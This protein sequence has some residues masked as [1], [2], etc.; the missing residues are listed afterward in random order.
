MQKQ[1]KRVKPAG[2]NILID[3]L[4]VEE[5]SAGGIVLSS[6]DVNKE[7][8]AMSVGK[9]LEFGPLCY[10]QM[11]SGA[12]SP[13]DWGVKDGDWVRFP[14]HSYMKTPTLEHPNV[15]MIIDHDIKAIVE[16]EE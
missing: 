14:S 1:V 8:A 15:V 5:T 10:K 9:V 12:N 13:S 4:K 11:E 3:L 16:L 2:Y 7:Q 6:S